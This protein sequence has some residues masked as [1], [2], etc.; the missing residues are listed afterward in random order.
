[1]QRDKEIQEARARFMQNQMNE[2]SDQ[3]IRKK[4][5]QA[6]HYS[7]KIKAQPEKHNTQ[8]SDMDMK[9]MFFSYWDSN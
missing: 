8:L 2:Q 7:K 3:H 4:E 1:M 5:K 9:T 6:K